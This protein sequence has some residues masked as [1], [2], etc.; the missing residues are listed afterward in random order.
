MLWTVA[1]VLLLL[2]VLGVMNASTMGGFL[3]LLLVAAIIL[4]VVRLVQGRKPVDAD[5]P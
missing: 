3:H 2:W 4:V 5:I 1:L